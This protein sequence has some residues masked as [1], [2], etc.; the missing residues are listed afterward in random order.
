LEVS[1]QYFGEILQIIYQK[2][3][4]SYDN[5]SVFNIIRIRTLNSAMDTS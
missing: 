4:V 2:Y 1:H 3:G 5:L